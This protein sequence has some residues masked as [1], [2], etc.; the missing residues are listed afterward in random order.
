[1]NEDKSVRYHRLKRQASVLSLLLTAGLLTGLLLSGASLTLR[2]LA[3]ALVDS[4]AAQVAV[5]LLLLG[6]V[7][8]IVGFPLAF[9]RTFVL[10]RQYELSRE[11]AA[12]WL[13]DHLKALLVGGMLALCAAET[14][15]AALRWSPRWWWVA[16]AAAFV[17]ATVVL[18]KLTPIVLLPLFYRF[19]PL[20]RES[21]H[22][23]LIT[24]S[25]RAGVP[26][27]GVYEWGLG[28]KTRRANAALVGTGRTRRILLS[29][30]LLAQY[31][32]DEI[33]VILAHELGHHVHRDIPK[34][35]GLDVA[36]LLA[37]FYA[38]AAALRAFWQ[39]LGLASPA[40]V[41]GLPLLLLVGGGASLVAAPVLN[42][43]SRLNERR[44]DC[45]ALTMTGQPSAFV[46]A[47]RRLASQN[48]AEEHPS[49]PALWFFHTHPPIS[50]RIEAAR[51]FTAAL[52]GQQ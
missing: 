41:A 48:L 18:A 32:D 28:E 34:T 38:A 35:L 26:V 10:E 8:E 30:T 23:R 22:A 43:I 12:V 19:K 7:Q 4:A 29:D 5:Y 49:R 46:S 51:T 45:Y 16:S 13:R 33:E 21:L 52:H 17:A 1:V 24:L 27:L 11:P 47:M 20:E 44:A 37:S 50:E 2:T 25:R 36:L 3:A 31:S 39:P 15:Y 42:A 40:D 14:I 9:Y 6:F